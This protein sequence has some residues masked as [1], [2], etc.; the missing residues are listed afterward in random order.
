MLLGGGDWD[1]LAPQ[2]RRPRGG[3]SRQPLA[4]LGGFG[5]GGLDTPLIRRIQ[6][7]ASVRRDSPLDAQ[8]P[9]A[10]GAGAAV[11]QNVPAISSPRFVAGTAEPVNS[12]VRDERL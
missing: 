5:L 3:I 6:P 2:P 7:A 1:G 9:G 8:P 12:T 11:E 4:L 10:E